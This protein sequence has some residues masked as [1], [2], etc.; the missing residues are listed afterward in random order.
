MLIKVNS[1][2]YRAKINVKIKPKIKVRYVLILS[3]FLVPG[4]SNKETNKKAGSSNRF[5]KKFD[6]TMKQNLIGSITPNLSDFRGNK[7]N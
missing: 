3:I 5:S 6:P 7:V 2:I 1:L 4:K